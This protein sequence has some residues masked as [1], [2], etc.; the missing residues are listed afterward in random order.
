MAITDKTRK[1][2]WGKSANRCNIEDCRIDLTIESEK[3]EHSVIGKECHIVAKSK[4]GP[5]G[6]TNLSLSKRDSYPNLMLLC[7]NHHDEIDNDEKKYTVEVLKAIKSKHEQWVEKAL[8]NKEITIEEFYFDEEG[9]VFDEEFLNELVEW[10]Q[11]HIKNSDID[12]KNIEDSISSLSY[13]NKKNRKLLVN[14]IKYYNKNKEIDIRS[15]Y[16]KL[17]GDKS[18]EHGEF[19]AGI[20]E[21]AKHKFVIFDDTPEI[22]EVGKET[23][24]IDEDSESEL[25]YLIK[26]NWLGI[27]GEVLYAL[28]KYFDNKEEQEL[29]KDLVVKRNYEVI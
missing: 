21:I 20:R 4:K 5:R 2:L 12:N 13:L 22:V 17:V 3:D 16:S 23:Y 19:Y 7:G 15:L 28:L 11:K 9:K 10:I 6:G 29:F 27:N 24:L 8:E 25:K 14:I 18:F 1:I 26:K